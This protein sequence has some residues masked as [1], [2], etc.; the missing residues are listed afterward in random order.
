MKFF[1]VMNPGSRSGKSKKLFQK[2]FDFLENQAVDYDY[3]IT[4][5]LDSAR[6]YSVAANQK[7]YDAI[8]A[9]GGDGTINKVVNGFFDDKGRRISTAKLGVLY[10][11]TSPDFCKS[12]DLPWKDIDVALEVLVRGNFRKINIGR[13][14]L[15]EKLN[16][17]LPVVRYFA[18]CAN[19]GLGATLARGANNGIRKYIG[20]NAGTFLS[21]LKTLATYRPNQFRIKVDGRNMETDSLHNL[22]VG[23]TKYI[24]SGIKVAH[25][26]PLTGKN[27]YILMIK[28]MQL[29]NLP[30]VF[31]KI[32][33]GKKIINNQVVSLDYINEIEIDENKQNPE[34]E[35]DG[36]P[37]GYLPCKIELSQDQL[38]LIC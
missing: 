32:Y 13:I 23:L 10:T 3:K 30:E 8:I 11:G 4:S 36:D 26:L 29:K 21:L 27:F 15:H 6:E 28:N 14:V 2:I 1:L 16:S 12:Y 17:P 7:K 34:V 37:H 20:D 5:S 18:C 22:S 9:V 25:D 24:A 31:Q 38:E 33:S 35:F 19:L